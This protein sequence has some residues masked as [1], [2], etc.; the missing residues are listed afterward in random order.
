[1]NN[2][3]TPETESR[4]VPWDIAVARINFGANCGPISFAAA[5][6]REVCRVMQFFSHFEEKPWT[7]LTHM[8]A[9]FARAGLETSTLRREWPKRGVALIQWLGPWSHRDFFSCWSLPHTHWLA[10]DGEWVFD[11]T[12]GCWMQKEEWARDVA[13]LFLQEIPH[14]TGWAVKYGLVSKSSNWL[15]SDFGSASSSG[16]TFNFSG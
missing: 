11:H 5:T 9:A 7:N 1:M 10:V 4:F 16:A 14:A 3:A 12:E 8:R 2:V 13:P 15:T 6:H